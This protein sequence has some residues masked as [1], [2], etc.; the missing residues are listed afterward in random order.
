[1][2][3]TRDIRCLTSTVKNVSGA[4]RYFSFLPFGGK[5]L[6]DQ[7]EMTYFGNIIDLIAC[8]FEVNTARKYTD[9][10]QAALLAGSL[11]IV[12]TPSPILYDTAKARSQTLRLDNT[13]LFETDLCFATTNA[14]ESV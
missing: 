4:A 1:M 12:T 7:E 10:L 13:G 8:R 2:P 9:A 14:S 5:R 3:A 6:D 11:T